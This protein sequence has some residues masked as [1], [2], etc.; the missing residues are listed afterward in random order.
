MMAP[1]AALLI[2]PTASSFIKPMAS[3]LVNAITRNRQEDEFLPLLA[4]RLMVKVLEKES[5]EQQKDIIVWIKIFNS[6]ISR[7]LSILITSPGLMVC[8]Q[9]TIYLE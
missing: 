8:F 4:L 5:E 6:A 2:A 7:L 1:M 9:E 3:S